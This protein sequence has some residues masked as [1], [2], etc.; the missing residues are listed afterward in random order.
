MIQR[1]NSNPGRLA[2]LLVLF[3]LAGCA[4][5]F[6]PPARD[7]MIGPA[8]DGSRLI[9]E[10]VGFPDLPG[11]TSD[12]QAAILPAFRKSCGRL[13]WQPND[14]PLDRKRYAGQVADWRTICAEAARL[15]QDNGRVR[16]F[17]EKVFIPYRAMNHEKSEGLFTAYYEPVLSGSRQRGGRYTVPI[18]SRPRDLVTV[19]LGTFYRDLSGRRIIGKVQDGRLRPYHDRA[20]INSGSLDGQRLE[21]VWVDDPVAVFFLHIQGSGQVAL[22]DGRRIRIGYSAQNGH[23]YR[24]IG[25]ELIRNGE[26][27]REGV[28][29]QS[30][31]NW[32]RD[33]PEK[34]RRLMEKNPSYIFFRE[35]DGEG[36]IGAQGVALTP[37]RSL[38]VDRRFIPLGVPLWVDTKAP[39]GSSWRDTK[40]LRR[41]FIAQDTGGAIR[42][43][44]RADIFWGTGKAAGENAGRM[45]HPG[46]Y[47]LLLPRSVAEGRAPA[48]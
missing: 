30:I 19:D 27:A 35:V 9:L 43:P 29:M 2:A 26:L 41:L 48:M 8:R 3:S 20:S 34:G 22:E 38:A 23:P 37:L 15:P 45:K 39:A 17:I 42:G 36:P 13:R 14:R 44:V 32:I 4:G 5:V 25:R 33:N 47:Y 12:Q 28:S 31:R 46:E 7:R 6:E 21:I 1:Q 18:H 24:S 10:R 16:D 11:W 40:P